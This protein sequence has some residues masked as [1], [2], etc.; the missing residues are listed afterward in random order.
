MK[1]AKIPDIKDPSPNLNWKKIE[2]E[3]E[4]T[5]RNLS[6]KLKESYRSVSSY[7]SNDQTDMLA[8]SMKLTRI[9]GRLSSLVYDATIEDE[10]ADD[11][12]I[13]ECLG[14]MLYEIARIASII[15]CDLTDVA[16]KALDF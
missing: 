12:E 10:R 14:E 8:S 5:L 9:N 2:E 4:L 11:D 6:E 15:D 13:L 1:F 3:P 16:E 7:L